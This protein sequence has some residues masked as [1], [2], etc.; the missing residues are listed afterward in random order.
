[1]DYKVGEIISASMP[2][3]HILNDK[4]KKKYC[5]FCLFP[6][7]NLKNCS[8]CKRLYY[9][10]RL[11]QKKD[12]KQHK[13]EC[14]HLKSNYEE[15]FKDDLNRLLLRLFL[16]IESDPKNAMKEEGLM[17]DPDSKRSFNDL[18]S[19]SNEIKNDWCRMKIFRNVCVDFE[20]SQINFDFLKLLDMF[21]KVCINSFSITNIELNEIGCGIF[22]A[23]S[24][25]DHSCQPNA[26]AVFNG[27]Y[28][29]IRAIKP[30]SNGS[31]ILINYIDM[32]ENTSVR[33]E[34]LQKQYYFHCDCD[35]CRLDTNSDQFY[36][37][38]NEKIK[39]MDQLINEQTGWKEAYQLGIES[40]NDFNRIYGDYHTDLTVQKVRVLKLRIYLASDLENETIQFIYEIEKSIAITHGYNHELYKLF[41][42][43]INS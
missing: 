19:H 18:M 41:K 40:L 24:Q 34:E 2:F 20:K 27:S 22:L 33:R 42:N 10:D 25:L 15:C 13:L 3:V 39:K 21:C 11:C 37:N 36:I 8:D 30:I 43:L 1:M 38:L 23:E 28:L 12:W 4:F 26:V 32:K 5:D 9:C 31:K 6:N 29:E 7:S 16:F 35:R 14:R 17:K